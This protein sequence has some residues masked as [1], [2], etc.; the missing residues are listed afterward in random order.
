MENAS[1]DGSRIEFPVSFDLKLIY[2]IA[3]A[4]TLNA[5][6]LAAFARRSVPCSA[7]EAKEP[8]PGAKYGRLSARVTFSSLEQL[9]ATY[10]E[11]GA[12][13]CVKGLL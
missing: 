11:V 12:L 13:P 5:D 6:L 2:D 9:R 4:A 7:I 10:A 8:K 1:F 3:A